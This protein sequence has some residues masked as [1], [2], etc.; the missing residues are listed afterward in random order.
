MLGIDIAAALLQLA[1]HKA[2]QQGL[3]NIEFRHGNFEPLGLPDESFDAI[4]CVF[5]IFFVPDK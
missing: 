1:R 4:V 3:N 2:Q 5:G